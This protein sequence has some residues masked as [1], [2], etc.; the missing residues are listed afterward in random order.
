[1]RLSTL[2]KEFT[3]NVAE[4]IQWAYDE[5]FEIT[6]GDAYRDARVHGNTNEKLSYSHKNSNH[7][8]R[9]AIDSNLFNQ[10]GEYLTETEDYRPLG[11]YWRSLNTNARWGESFNDGCHFSFE[12]KGQI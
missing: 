2:Q 6:L 5:G 8:R 3:I 7:K 12:W 1:M 11:E 4:L 10:E 9:L